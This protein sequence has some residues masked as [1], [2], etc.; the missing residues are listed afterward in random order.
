LD[1]LFE[2]LKP[3]DLRVDGGKDERR[4][5]RGDMQAVPLGSQ[6]G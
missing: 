6:I 1:K 3:T 2:F 4:E 5:V